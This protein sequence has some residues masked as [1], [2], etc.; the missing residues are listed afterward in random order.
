MVLCPNSIEAKQLNLHKLPLQLQVYTFFLLQN[1]PPPLVILNYF[2]FHSYLSFK[3][4]KGVKCDI[5]TWCCVQ[6]QLEDRQATAVL[7]MQT[8]LET[9]APGSRSSHVTPPP[10][11][12]QI[13]VRFT[14]SFKLEKGVSSTLHLQITTSP[15]QD[16]TPN[17]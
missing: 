6:T 11:G 7:N 16:S 4:T 17:S 10:V 15:V 5:T 3:T 2:S 13:P 1:T 9:F 14:Y 12:E 8:A